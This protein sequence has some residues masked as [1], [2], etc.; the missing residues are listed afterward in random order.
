M[1][2]GLK[3]RNPAEVVNSQQELKMI[4]SFNV[5]KPNLDIPPPGMSYKIACKNDVVYYLGA[6]PEGKAQA[7]ARH[8]KAINLFVWKANGWLSLNFMK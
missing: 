6:C 8:K 3:S 2:P 4:K 7:F 1:V 5:K